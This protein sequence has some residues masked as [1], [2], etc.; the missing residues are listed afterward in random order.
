MT[1]RFGI[2]SVVRIGRK[3]TTI[4][5]IYSDI[6]GGRWVKP[7]VYGFKSWNTDEMTL[8]TPSAPVENTSDR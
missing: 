5:G 7:E 6:P 3:I 8:V 4:D 1:E 2:G